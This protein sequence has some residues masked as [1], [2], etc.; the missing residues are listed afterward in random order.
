MCIRDRNRV[1]VAFLFA[2]ACVSAQNGERCEK[3]IFNMISIGY[4]VFY[5]QNLTERS[6]RPFLE[7]HSASRGL[8]EVF[9]ACQDILKIAMST[10]ISSNEG[11]QCFNNLKAAIITLDSLTAKGLDV[12]NGKASIQDFMLPKE[13]TRKVFEALTMSCVEASLS[14]ASQS[15]DRNCQSLIN[16]TKQMLSQ[17]SG[18]FV[19]LSA[20]TLNYCLPSIQKRS[21]QNK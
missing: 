10:K 3:S 15:D 12:L 6:L 2:L 14:Y 17:S 1:F 18:D 8:K 19:N 21:K 20:H 9:S 13:P 7:S 5:A 16:T 11:L 4:N